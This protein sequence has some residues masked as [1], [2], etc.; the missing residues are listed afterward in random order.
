MKAAWIAAGL[1]LMCLEPAWAQYK[2]E[3]PEGKIG[4]QQTPCAPGE[5]Q[6]SLDLRPTRPTAPASVPAEAAPSAAR[7]PTAQERLLASYER[8]RKVLE[9]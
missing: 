1:C 3:G 8:D 2:C 4:F 7:A 5:R 6:Q 9:R